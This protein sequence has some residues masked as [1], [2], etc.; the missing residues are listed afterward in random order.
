MNAPYAKYTMT[1]QEVVSIDDTIPEL[2][3]FGDD[4]KDKAIREMVMDMYWNWEIAG[5]TIGEFK[6]MLKHSFNSV[7][8]YYNEMIDAY[9]TKINM[10]DGKKTTITVKVNDTT[11]ESGHNEG[12]SSGTNDRD[13]SSSTSKYDLPRS[14]TTEN[15]PSGKTEDTAKDERSSSSSASNDYNSSKAATKD[16]NIEKLGSESV[17]KLKQEYMSIIRNIYKECA[18]SLGK[19]FLDLFW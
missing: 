6:G 2:L 15:R 13:T 1:Y 7:R 10:L 9:Q 12:S 3:T 8:D 16:K 17:I 4:I 11:T 14:S 5:E 18:N 19:C